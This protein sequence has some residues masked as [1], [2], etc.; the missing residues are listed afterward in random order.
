MS[1]VELEAIIDRSG[2]ASTLELAL[3]TGGRPRQLRVRTLLLGMLAAA[4]DDRPAHLVRVHRGL[5][6]LDPA[7]R[8]RLGVDVNWLAGPHTL[9][10]RQVERTFGLVVAALDN[11]ERDGCPS[12]T[13]TAL[14]DTL[15]EA[16]I[17]ETY[18]HTSSALAVD[19]TDH[20]SWA[21]APHSNEVGAD[22]DASWGHRASHA[23]GVKDELFYG[24]SPQTA[25]MVANE[26]GPAVPELARRILVTSCHVDPP[27]AFVGVLQRM[28]HTGI[29]IG[30]VLADSGYAHRAATGWALPL[31]RLGARLIQDLHPHDRGPKGTHGG[32]VIANGNLYCPATPPT[33]LA[34]GPLARHADATDIAAHDTASAEAACYKL[35]RITA[36]DVDGYHRVACPAVAGKLRCPLRDDS[37]SLPHDRPEILNPPPSLPPCCTQQTLTVPP[38]V[39]AKTAQKH[40]YPSA[41]H[42]SSYARR[43]AAERTFATIKDPASTNT[44]RGWCRIMGLTAITLFLACAFVARNERVLHAFETRQAQDTRRLAAGRPSKTRRRRRRTLADLVQAAPP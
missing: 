2:I 14:V 6:G 16:S 25:T 44:T 28:H 36:E 10:Y 11:H 5:L 39:N 30:D 12:E 29:T 43:T 40:D 17:P 27:R 20:E 34:L 4:S 19:W 22:P 1:I 24:Y 32:A 38:E 23:I 37:M 41:A 13:L 42:R 33:L 26:G 8:R 9:T 18:K 31:R 35:G 15:M 3:P 7:D 21:L